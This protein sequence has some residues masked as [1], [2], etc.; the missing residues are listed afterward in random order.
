MG[1]DIHEVRKYR[2]ESDRN[3]SAPYG[4]R[5]GLERAPGWV[6]AKAAKAAFRRS[7]K[8]ALYKR[9]YLGDAT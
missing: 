2:D 6:Q 3:P 4:G 8:E 7:Q 1:R 5:Q 9:R